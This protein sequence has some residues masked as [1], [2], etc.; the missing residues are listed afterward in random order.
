M[1]CSSSQARFYQKHLLSLL[2][3]ICSAQLVATTAYAG[4]VIGNIDGVMPATET[5]GAY[6]WGWACETGDTRPIDLH[7]YAGG[8]YAQGGTLATS[9][10]ANIANEAA[11]NS[12][13]QTALG[14]PH[15]FR[16]P[17]STTTLLRF[18][19]LKAYIHGISLSGGANNLINKS[20]QYSIPYVTRTLRLSELTASLPAGADLTIP[21]S[22]KVTIDTNADLGILK[23]NGQLLCPSTGNF[24]VRA[25]GILVEGTGSRFECGNDTQGFTGN[26]SIVMK[27]GRDLFSGHSMGERAFAA[28]SGGVIRLRG[29]GKRSGWQ[30]I[31][32]TITAG[33]QTVN[34]E[35]TAPD[36]SVGDRIVIGP[37]SFKYHEADER[38]ITAIDPTDRV[39][40]VNAPFSYHHFGT[41][42]TFDNGRQSWNLDERA[43]IANLTRNIRILSAGSDAALDDAHSARI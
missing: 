36:W 27:P 8:A 35:R 15:R 1:K 10:R 2:F 26:L 31:A 5:T 3:R 6:V 11:V 28:M 40:T 14:T 30:R 23:I 13:C 25:A 18:A 24:V 38:I 9:G 37:T 17:L 12:A 29:N 41:V 16:I 19:G 39:I 32:S 22:T 43:E 33:S 4:N 34:L 7:L 42:Q 20:G 21:P